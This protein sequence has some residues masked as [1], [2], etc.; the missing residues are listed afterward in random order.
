MA[1]YFSKHEIS[2]CRYRH[3]HTSRNLS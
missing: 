3:L 2:L 1:N